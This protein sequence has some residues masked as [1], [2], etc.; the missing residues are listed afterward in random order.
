MQV[1]NEYT[2]ILPEHLPLKVEIVTVMERVPWK[3][4]SLKV[5]E[6]C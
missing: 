5:G 2:L 3:N 1:W 4:D 6:L